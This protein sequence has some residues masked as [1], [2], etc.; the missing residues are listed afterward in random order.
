M[1]TRGRWVPYAAVIVTAVAMWAILMLLAPRA[2]A[3]TTYPPPPPTHTVPPS[4]PTAHTG[5]EGTH[6]ALAAGVLA[7]VGVGLISVS[8]VARR[9]AKAFES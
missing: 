4:P 7:I 3:A 5:F 9:R 8:A 2:D 1:R 6:D